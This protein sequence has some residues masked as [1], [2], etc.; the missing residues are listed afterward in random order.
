[1]RSDGARI[2]RV[3][4]GQVHVL[5]SSNLSLC[6][7]LNADMRPRQILMVR[8]GREAKKN[9][10]IL[11]YETHHSQTACADEL[12]EERVYCQLAARNSKSNHQDELKQGS[13]G[14]SVLSRTSTQDLEQSSQF[15]R[16]AELQPLAHFI[17][18]CK[19]ESCQDFH[20]DGPRK[21]NQS[22]TTTSKHEDVNSVMSRMQER[23]QGRTRGQH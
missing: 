7:V 5:H 14:P 10:S 9:R 4:E 8:I 1:M 6:N 23:H 20:V 3:L 2:T 15:I 18:D 19:S 13:D 16:M 21:I 22:Q 12:R 11:R 17:E